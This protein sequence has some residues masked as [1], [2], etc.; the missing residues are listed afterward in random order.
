MTTV[1]FGSR[2]FTLFYSHF[3]LI[4]MLIGVDM[5]SYLIV[6]AESDP[7]YTCSILGFLWFPL[8]KTNAWIYF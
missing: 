3:L 7:L 4:N 6:L 5:K 8:Y 2:I 1:C